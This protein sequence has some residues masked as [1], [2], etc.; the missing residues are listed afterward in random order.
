MAGVT[1]EW[2]E[3][4]STYTRSANDYGDIAVVQKDADSC[5][6]DS[7]VYRTRRCSLN[8]VQQAICLEVGLFCRMWAHGCVVVLLQVANRALLS[9]G[10]NLK[11]GAPGEGWQRLVVSRWQAPEFFGWIGMACPTC[12]K[13]FGGEADQSFN[14]SSLARAAAADLTT[15]T[16]SRVR[17]QEQR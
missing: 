3:T 12:W 16:G 1:S 9:S 6:L 10:K 2:K 15:F 13:S 8:V 14:C 17:L 11:H 5:A 7:Q 4:A